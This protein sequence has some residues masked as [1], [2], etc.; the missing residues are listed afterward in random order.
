MVD[1]GRYDISIL[2]WWVF[3]RTTG[4]HHP[5]CVVAYH[6][7]ITRYHVLNVKGSPSILSGFHQQTWYC[8]ARSGSWIRFF[9][10][11]LSETIDMEVSWVIGVPPNRWF[12]PL[13]TMQRAWGYLHDYGNPQH[14]PWLT[15]IFPWLTILFPLIPRFVSD[16]GIFSPPHLFLSKKR[17]KKS[18]SES[19]VLK[20][21][22]Q[23]HG[24]NPW[25]ARWWSRR[26]TKCPTPPRSS[27][28][29]RPGSVE[30]GCIRAT[31]W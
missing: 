7:S 18:P 23:W 8:K 24:P 14:V 27:R 16:N 10:M 13:Q 28:N 21:K 22:P 4:R 20:P 26:A 11:I 2:L 3:G 12:F 30:R 6:S 19:Q 25:C 5:A 31:L 15:S 17:I 29:P 9:G 1:H